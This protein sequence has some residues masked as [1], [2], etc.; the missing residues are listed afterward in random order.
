M[1]RT[2]QAALLRPNGCSGLSEGWRWLEGEPSRAVTVLEVSERRRGVSSA[3]VTEI[4]E[5]SLSPCRRC[6]ESLVIS[7]LPG[8]RGVKEGQLSKE[9]EER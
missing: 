9:G 2:T 3:A 4:V 5:L 8:V 6:S 7:P 1:L